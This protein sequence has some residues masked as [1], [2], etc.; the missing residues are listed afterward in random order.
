MPTVLPNRGTGTM[1]RSESW[2]GLGR[3]LS[4]GMDRAAPWLERLGRLGHAAIGV[5]YLL[6]GVLAAEA[7][8]GAGGA[9]T[10][11]KG[12]MRHVQRLPFGEVLLV[13]VAIGLGGYALWRFVQAF[14]DTER[15]GTS[16]KGAA[17]RAGYAASGLVHAALAWSAVELAQ[18]RRGHGDEAVSREHTA[19]LL[20][21]PY[22]PELVCVV[23][24]VIIGLGLAQLF[25]AATAPFRE[26]LRPM[27]PV[28][29]AWTVRL[30]RL[31][32]LAR[33]MVFGVIGGFLVSAGV[34]ANPR[35]AR[36]L[37]GALHALA[38]QPSGAWL[39]GTVAAGLAAYGVFMLLLARYRRMVIR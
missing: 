8:L 4:D 25:L 34:H 28:A 9:V 24:A 23:G 18:G 38:R 36:G 22:G 11:S 16:L 35:D 27:H 19:R 30:G 29:R 31:G 2:T 37:A 3:A 6:V 1:A 10:G 20:A 33:G 13:A 26:K 7:A 14:R 5:V 12:A 15:E 21:L 39:F 17:V 32:Y